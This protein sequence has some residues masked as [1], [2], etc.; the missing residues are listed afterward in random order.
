MPDWQSVRDLFEAALAVPAVNREGFVR[1]QAARDTDLRD[2]VLA[3]L[4]AHDD[5][6]DSLEEPGAALAGEGRF[7]DPESEAIPLRESIGP[8]RIVSRLG[9]GGM[10]EVF[11]GER[12]G[13]EFSQRVAI[14]LVTGGRESRSVVRRFLV[15]RR[16]LSAL[17]HPGIARLIDGG[18]TEDGLPLSGHGVRAR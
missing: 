17:D 12:A 5:A 14:K 3:L 6:G 15:E 16:I 9:Q 13:E 4:A 8:W 7:S 18:S 10:G 1:A 11:L 2:E